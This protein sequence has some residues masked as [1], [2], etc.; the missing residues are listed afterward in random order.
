MSGPGLCT[1]SHSDEK[2]KL[3]A[4]MQELYADLRRIAQACLRRERPGHTLQPTALVNE[5]YM[6]LAGQ[7]NL[8]WSCRPQILAI[9]A[10]MMRRILVNYAEAHHAQKR[11][12]GRRVTLDD[13]LALAQNRDI[14]VQALDQALS[15][16]EQIDERQVRIV[17]LRFFS[18]L[19]VEE[20]ADVLGVSSAT[21]KREW[22]SARLWLS[23]EIDRARQ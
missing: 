14:D 15:R 1:E 8:D 6:R 4:R 17:E 13:R 22:Q 5:A 2:W 19:G 18:G 7:H 9:A 11:A 3:D 10:S 16:L 12:G 20:T 21:V 23:R